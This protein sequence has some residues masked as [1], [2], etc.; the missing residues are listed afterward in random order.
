M[1]AGE[2]A[3][4]A[5]NAEEA[6]AAF[7]RAAKDDPGDVLALRNLAS[8]KERVGDARGAA[9]AYEALA[10]CCATVSHRLQAWD[11]AARIW[12]DTGNDP[13]RALSALRAAAAIDPDYSDV[14]DRLASAYGTLGMSAELAELLRAKS[15]RTQ[16]Q[17]ERRALEVR[18]GRVLIA[19]GNAAE[20]KAAFES[21]L[22]VSPDDLEALSRLAD[23]YEADEDWERAEQ[24]LVR[25]GRLLAS[26]D[27]QL[28]T[29]RR[30]ANIYSNRLLNFPRA[31]VALK[32]VLKR[33][34]DDVA[35]AKN[36]V[37][38]FKQQG[39]ATRAIEVQEQLFARATAPEDKRN[40]AL[41]LA[42][43]QENVARD[44]RSAEKTFEAARR[45]LP[46]DFI[47]L[48]AMV[49]FYQRHRQTPAIKILLD[50][51]A[52][53]ARRA[54]S[55]G[56]IAPGTFE[57]IAGVMEL[58]GRSGSATAARAM[59]S[60][61]QGRSAELP[62]VAERAFD[63]QLDE[64]VAPETFGPALRALLTRA[65]DALDGAAP[66][67]L[68]DLRATPMRPDGVVCRRVVRIAAAAGLNGLQVYVSAKLGYA[69]LP[70]AS[71]PPAIILGEAATTDERP[72]LF[73]ATRA[74]KL[75]RAKASVFARLAGNDL[76]LL[77]GA[78]L[79]CFNPAWQPAWIPA[80]T[81]QQAVGRMRASSTHT[82]D[83]QLGALALEVTGSM[84]TQAKELG[85]AALAWADRVALLALGDPLSALDA[86]AAST[87]MA[88]APRDAPTRALWVSHSAEAR[89]LMLFAVSDAVSQIYAR[90]GLER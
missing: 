40:R 79:K 15:D 59:L 19:L 49:T 25:L 81:L 38:V 45:E 80:A 18:R 9:E 4:S 55:A 89:D 7:E 67:N 75:V 74:L 21:A 73:L 76:S 16:D 29:Y 56:Q 58:R 62:A 71:S 42:A 11:E 43:L 22:A 64:L 17:D 77:V 68:R 13:E 70:V 33:A 12:S 53:D 35:A 47:L 39:D 46:Q 8:V 60:A 69:C 32:E 28:G 36:L 34:P 31:E 37:D 51:V 78:W 3:E 44:A 86:I 24:A 5:G 26:A 65:G 1:R 20:A 63:P 41:E 57:L 23:L 52:S 66:L 48:Q 88:P 61:I 6:C 30:L 50:R 85:I 2:A 84:Q 10:R 83:P 90:L 54:L 72:C 82:V 27:G 14:F 87:G